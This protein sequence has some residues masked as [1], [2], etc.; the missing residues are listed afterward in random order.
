M[1]TVLLVLHVLICVSLIVVVLIQ[2]SE[3][4]GFGMGSG[5][6][7]N[8]FSGR[9]AANLLTRTT[10]ILAA[11]FIANSL[12]LSILVTR[13]SDSSL[14]DTIQQQES[15]SAPAVPVIKEKKTDAAKSESKPAV[16]VGE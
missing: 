10:A 15:T 13:K 5:S 1:E 12:L 9:A 7:A 8:V 16:P 6:G 3:S 11:L 14:M 4:D 2:R